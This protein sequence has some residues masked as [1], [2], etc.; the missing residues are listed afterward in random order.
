MKKLI[1][2]LILFVAIPAMAT[3]EPGPVGRYQ[4]VRV[5]LV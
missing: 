2:A 3:D 1:F 5:A 4:A